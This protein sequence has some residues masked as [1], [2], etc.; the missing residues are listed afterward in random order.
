M[1][2]STT[3]TLKFAGAA[4]ERGISRVQSAFKSLGGV[5]MRIGKSLVSPFAVIAAAAGGLLAA[6]SLFRT[7]VELN[8]IGE[9]GRAG[10][11][12]LANVTKQMGL[13]GSQADDV[14]KRL[15][16]YADVTSRMTGV[17]G[18]SIG[19]AQ[20]KLMTF[21]ELA[22]S[23]NVAGGAF[24]RATMAAIDMASAGFG[25]AE[26]NAVQLGKA[27]NDPIKGITSLTRSGITFTTQEKAKIQTLVESNQMLKAQDMILKAIET[28]VGGTAEAS[29]TS[30]DKIKA[31][32][33]QIK[34]AFAEPLSMG[35]DSMPGALE[36]VFPKIIAK[37]EELGKLIGSTISDAVNGDLTRFFMI[38]ELIGEVIA[39]GLEISLKSVGSKISDYL[40]DKAK[41]VNLPAFLVDKSLQEAIAKNPQLGEQIKIAEEN[42]K[43]QDKAQR[44]KALQIRVGELSKGI[45]EKYRDAIELPRAQ[46]MPGP[47]PRF[48][49]FRYATP[50]DTGNMVDD[51]GHRIMIDIK[52]G[53]DALNQ[54][55]APQP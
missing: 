11:R 44:S 18:E 37:A 1:A 28:Q 2:I 33:A 46:P 54:K 19:A 9:A 29:A 14:T 52:T 22:K 8:A 38:G 48:P 30:S 55:L 25:S 20:T 3:F 35:V 17:D 26:M 42:V 6:R 32:F 49:G 24:D 23:A 10:D 47:H 27:L 16:D 15:I 41:Y 39:A 53:I 34:D 4:V 51:E 13:F 21:K 45:Q 12:A 31:S 7:A 50:D 40:G 43:K 36:S 5:A